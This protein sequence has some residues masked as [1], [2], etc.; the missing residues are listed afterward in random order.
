M[1]TRSEHMQNLDATERARDNRTYIGEL[2]RLRMIVDELDRG[3]VLW[4][5][6]ARL[7]VVRAIDNLIREAEEADA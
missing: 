1:N 7:A 2:R 3:G 5:A 6:A 4:I